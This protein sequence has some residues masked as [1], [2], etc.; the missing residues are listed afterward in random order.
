MQRGIY[1][2]GGCVPLK[3]KIVN[4]YSIESTNRFSKT[5]NIYIIFS[6]AWEEVVDTYTGNLYVVRN[7]TKSTNGLCPLYNENGQIANINDN[8]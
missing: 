5:G 3:D 7:G 2:I 8:K 1:F 6:Y 4:E